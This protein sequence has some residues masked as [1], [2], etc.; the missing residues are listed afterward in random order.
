MAVVQVVMPAF[1]AAEFIGE[2]IDSVLAQTFTDWESTV[3]DDGSID[4]TPDI[5]SS[6]SDDRVRL[7][8]IEHSGL[9][10]A[11]N[12]GLAESRSPFVAFLD[13]DDFWRREKLNA[14]WQ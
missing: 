6:Y 11:R 9:A 2:A 5:V 14:K 10:A 13:A 4:G 3:V 12:R 7:L 8:R 1:N